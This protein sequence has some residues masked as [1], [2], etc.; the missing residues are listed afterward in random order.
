MNIVKQGEK[1]VV[2]TKIVGSDTVEVKHVTMNKPSNTH[3]A[4]KW[5]F[6]FSNVSREDLMKLATRALVIDQRPKFKDE[7]D[8]KKLE[9]WD[10]RTFSVAKIL[11]KERARVSAEEKATRAVTALPESEQI[12]LLK[13]LL[14]SKGIEI[15]EAI[16]E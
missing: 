8:S 4:M 13:Q 2:G 3:Y 9:T 6:D 12:A 11:A 5:S 14:A 10:N 7:K 1:R 16:E 15:D